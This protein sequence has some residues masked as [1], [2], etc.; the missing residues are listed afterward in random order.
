MGNL[1]ISAA[2]SSSIFNAKGF[3]DK[4]RTT[5]TYLQIFVLAG[6]FKSQNLPKMPQ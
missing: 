4:G 2:W 5:H 6:F 1:T 3:F